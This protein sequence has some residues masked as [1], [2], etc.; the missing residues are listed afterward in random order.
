MRDVGSI[1]W[2]ILVVV[3]VVSSI[4]SN[5]RRQARGISRPAA[6][7]SGAP[8]A[9]LPAANAGPAPAAAAP[10]KPAPAST[11]PPR[12]ARV[13]RRE[14]PPEP[15]DVLHPRVRKPMPA[16]HPFFGDRRAMVRAVVAA[17]VLGKPLALRDA[18]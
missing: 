4:V 12:A 6:P 1:V 2:V 10:P 14:P 16:W 13:T 7:R 5:A 3:G 15:L 17:E 11:A 9:R 18:P 8:A